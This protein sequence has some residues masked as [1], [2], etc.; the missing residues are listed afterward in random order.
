MYRVPYCS[1][2]TLTFFN[3]RKIT[4]RVNEENYIVLFVFVRGTQVNIIL[5]K[6]LLPTTNILSLPRKL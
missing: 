5:L 4:K 2:Q 3:F 1:C 6:D